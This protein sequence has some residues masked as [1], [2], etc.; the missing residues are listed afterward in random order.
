VKQSKEIHV[1]HLVA[2]QTD[3]TD[4]PAPSSS[5]PCEGV[6]AER[7][8][9]VALAFCWADILIELDS[10]ANVVFVAG[11]VEA[12]TGQ[13]VASLIGRPIASLVAPQDGLLIEQLLKIASKRGRVEGIALRLA[14]RRGPTRHLSVAGYRLENV[15]GHYFL[16]LRRPSS[17]RLEWGA[18]PLVRD[19]DSGLYDAGSLLD[20]VAAEFAET[21]QPGRWV[22]FVAVVGYQELQERL[23][24]TAEQEL[25]LEIGTL[26][27]AA[28]L[29]RDSAGRIG[30]GRFGVLHGVGVDIDVLRRRLLELV[31]SADPEQRGLPI[32]TATIATD[33][34]A[35][36]DQDGANALIYMINRFRYLHGVD[37][38]AK[39]LTAV[40]NELASEAVATV[41]AF[42]RAIA[43]AEFD[44]AFQPIIDVRTGDIHHYEA[45]A[46]FGTGHTPRGPFAHITYA[47]E[48][49]LIAEFD[50][51]MATKVIEWLSR[52]PL[53]ENTCVAVNV[54]GVSVGCLSYLAGL[55]ALLDNN[56][57]ARGRLMFEIT[58]SARM[59]RLGPANA[60]IQR[61]R[62]NG[63]PVCIDDFGA[64]AADF[65]YLSRLEVD[66]VK[67]DGA[68]IR[69]ARRD[70]KGK[71]FLKALVGLCRELGVATIAEMVEDE[72]GLDFIRECGVQYAQG[73]LFGEPAPDIGN[74]GARMPRQLFS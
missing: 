7:D 26:L 60:F 39:S 11:A 20:V 37:Y 56:R 9:F 30:L 19:A 23:S 63:Y 70:R 62:R 28:S 12:M 36:D 67:L 74:F 51:A 54:S 68:A 13:S 73:H 61:L 18:K 41:G 31:R 52:I 14:G 4:M 15:D 27:R 46:R 55:D 47:E 57:W 72:P 8:R 45:L 71:A 64:G 59:E 6:A 69:N 34:A 10:A 5:S 25:L 32:H 53:D 3:S 1:A 44:I 42:R 49:G 22:T 43:G 65:Q 24:K 48:N 17:L 66:I 33:H 16:A 35:L 29:N 2:P 58:E 40:V 38:T 50:L 21:G